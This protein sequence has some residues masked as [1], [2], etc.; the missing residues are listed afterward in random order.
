VRVGQRLMLAV[1]PAVV[2]VLSVA[3]LAYWGQYARQAPEIVIVV[4]VIAALVSL[5]LAWWNTQYVAHRVERLAS[6]SVRAAERDAPAGHTPGDELD[7]IELSVHGLRDAVHAARADQTERER[8]AER[9]TAEWSALVEEVVAQVAD[10]VHEVQ[11][12]LHILLESPFG[13]LNENQE[14]MLAAARGAA[15]AADVKLRQARK[16]IE[17]EHGTVAMHPR[18]IGLAELLRPALAIAEARAAK[19]GVT[20]RA[21]LSPA[22]PRALADPMYAQEAVTIALADAVER[23]PAAG[24]LHVE[25]AELDPTTLRVRVTGAEYAT[26]P[27]L[28]MRLAERLVHAQGGAL[29]LGAAEMTIDLPAEQMTRLRP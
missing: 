2:G 14:E 10:G 22:T 23:T 12:P 26:P 27:S 3:A 11:L 9:R 7:A 17:L 15:E 25:T 18:P 24:D 19:R 28:A 8:A 29:R 1:L 20:L 4:A 5:A 6:R 21:V 13:A 16:L